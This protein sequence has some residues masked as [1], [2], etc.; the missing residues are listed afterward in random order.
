VVAT[1]AIAGEPTEILPQH[2]HAA[3]YCLWLLHGA[4]HGDE[5]TAGN[6]ITTVQPVLPR[7]YPPPLRSQSWSTG[8]DVVEVIRRGGTIYR[9]GREDPYAPASLFM[10]GLSNMS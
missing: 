8:T 9:L 2:P 6:T 1:P 7:R 10:T 3:P 5:R 4:L